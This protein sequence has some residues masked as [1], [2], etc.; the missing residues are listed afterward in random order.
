MWKVTGL[1]YNILI[2]YIEIVKQITIL[3]YDP[4][5]SS[6]FIQTG[7]AISFELPASI[8]NLSVHI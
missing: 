4:S 3:F 8:I 2:A 7:A 1:R 6:P 5:S